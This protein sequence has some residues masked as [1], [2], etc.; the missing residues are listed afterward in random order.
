MARVFRAWGAR[1]AGAHG[2]FPALTVF[3]MALGLH[4]VA[5]ALFGNNAGAAIFCVY[6]CAMMVGAWCGYGPGVVVTLLL[7]VLPSWLLKPGWTYRELNPAGVVV[8][9]LI[10]LLISRAAQGRRRTESRLRTMND[11]L[12]ARVK[13]KTAQLEEVNEALQRNVTELRRVNADLEQF[14]YSASH[15]LQ[16]PLRM[17]SVFTQLLNQKYGGQ[18]DGDAQQYLT[19]IVE[20]AGR[21][22]MLIHGLR[23]YITIKGDEPLALVDAS[24]AVQSCVNSLRAAVEEQQARIEFGE[25]PMVR[26]PQ[27][28]L[29]QVFQN[30]IHNALKYRSKQEPHV[31]ITASK[32]G[33]FWCFAVRDNGIGIAAQYTKQI[34][35]VFKRLHTYDQYQGSGIGLA[36]CKRI[37]ERC[38]GRIWVESSVGRGSTFFFTLPGA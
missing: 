16:E 7:V 8:L 25:L 26:I 10:S 37:V 4:W 14:A 29:E 34:F 30:L 11:E 3:V 28:H 22:E 35:G 38:G 32:D 9:L 5:L 15:D 13:Q 12:E 24:A 18:L 21:M 36:I 17:V 1:L 23:T 33:N 2:F 27:A 6:L 31:Q 20:G 19:H